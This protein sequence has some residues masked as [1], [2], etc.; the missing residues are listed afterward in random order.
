MEAADSCNTTQD[1]LL[2]GASAI[3]PGPKPKPKGPRPTS[4]A[5]PAASYKQPPVV[6]V[7]TSPRSVPPLQAHLGGL[8][9]M[10]LGAKVGS[11]SDRAAF[12][13][14]REKAGAGPPSSRGSFNI[15]M[16]NIHQH[17]G[18]QASNPSPSLSISIT[19]C[20]RLTSPSPTRRRKQ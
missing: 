18:T 12:D 14:A 16:T 15:S 8:C 4:R 7:S 3:T 13:S 10:C 20:F 11:R 1:P 2:P 17:A 6:D 9:P 5:A 19:H